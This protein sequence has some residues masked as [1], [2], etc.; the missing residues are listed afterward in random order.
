MAGQNIKFTGVV[1]RF[2]ASSSGEEIVIGK[3]KTSDPKKMLDL[4]E[5][6]EKNKQK[7]EGT[8]E[9]IQK[10]LPNMEETK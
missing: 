9:L 10:Q 2:G 6:K 3:A 8:M 1:K 5:A 4:A 7:V